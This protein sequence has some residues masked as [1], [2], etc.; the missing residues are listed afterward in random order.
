L[1]T[2]ACIFSSSFPKILDKRLFMMIGSFSC[3]QKGMGLGY[4]IE[5][6]MI[7]DCAGLMPGG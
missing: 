7:I 4:L 1:E 6:N 2:D 5:I 3:V